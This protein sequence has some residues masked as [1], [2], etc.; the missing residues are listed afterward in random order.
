MILCLLKSDFN[1]YKLSNM[2]SKT[3]PYLLTEEQVNEGIK[4]CKSRITSLLHDAE[5]VCKNVNNSKNAVGL[6]TIA[7]EECGKL[8]L[9]QDSLKSERN[10]GGIISIDKE[11]FGKGSGHTKIK[12]NRIL[13]IL[14]DVCKK[15]GNIVGGF[16]SGFGD[17]FQKT[18]EEVLTDFRTR[19][20][21]FYV[22]WDEIKNSWKSGLDIESKDLL[23]AIS[24]FRKWLEDNSLDS[25]THF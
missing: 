17:G 11:I 21:I 1:F 13:P 2:S 19:K 15:V 18:K 14:P 24:A 20:D 6:Y 8:L 7:I 10:S 25:K 9:L 5:I 12:F 23:S 3:S 16:S 4:L 22:D